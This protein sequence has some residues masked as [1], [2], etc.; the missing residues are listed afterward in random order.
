MRAVV[1]RV[2]RSSVSVDGNTVGSIGKGFCVLLGISVSDTEKDAEYIVRKL[3]NLRVFEDSEGRMNLSLPDSL[4]DGEV[5]EALV[6]SQFTLYADTRRGNRPS[7]IEAAAPEAARPLYEFFVSKLRETGFRVETGIFQ[8]DMQVELVN[9][10]PVT[11]IL[12]SA[13]A[14]K[15]RKG[16]QSG[17]NA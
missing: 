5:P 6:I 11:I 2:A 17:G 3:V 9:S 13:D 1:Q 15:P 4:E 12:D 16:S 7:F 8:A 10:G 14:A